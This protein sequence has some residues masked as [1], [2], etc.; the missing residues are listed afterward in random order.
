MYLSKAQPRSHTTPRPLRLCS[1]CHWGRHF[2][3]ISTVRSSAEAGWRG[4]S[5]PLT[6]P[7]DPHRHVAP[8]WAITARDRLGHDARDDLVAVGLIDGPH[9]VQIDAPAIR[10]AEA[11]PVVAIDIEG[12]ARP[13]QQISNVNE[14]NKRIMS[15]VSPQAMPFAAA[16]KPFPMI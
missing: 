16:P 14:S 12:S 8:F 3:S 10:L 13:G 5:T 15:T 2:L 7:I 11:R 9:Y 1:P 6:I 4:C